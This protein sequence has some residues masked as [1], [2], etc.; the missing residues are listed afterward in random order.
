MVHTQGSL[1]LEIN[2]RD[3]QQKSADYWTPQLHDMWEFCYAFILGHVYGN[4]D[5]RPETLAAT[6]KW[7]GEENIHFVEKDNK[8]YDYFQDQCWYWKPESHLGV[9]NDNAQ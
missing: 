8:P 9:Q 3:F 5:Y 6:E 4:L 1:R 2:V 7:L